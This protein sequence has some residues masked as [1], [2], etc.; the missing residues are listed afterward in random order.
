MY[1]LKGGIILRFEIEKLEEQN[2][3]VA[4]TTAAAVTGGIILVG[5]G[6]GVATGYY[7][8]K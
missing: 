8:N 6:A 1:K 5:G 3:P 7:V 4:L 2:Q